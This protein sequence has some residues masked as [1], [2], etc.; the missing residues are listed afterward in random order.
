MSVLFS[1]GDQVPVMPFVEVVGS[2]DK[3]APEQIG[4]T[5]ANTGVIFELTMMVI[6]VVVAHKPIS[7]VN[8]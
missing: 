5:G 4:A 7:G 1:A 8:V 2:A 3:A 6:V